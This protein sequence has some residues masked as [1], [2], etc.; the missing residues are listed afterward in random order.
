MERNKDAALV[1]YERWDTAPDSPEPPLWTAKW[2]EVPCNHVGLGMVRFDPTKSQC[3]GL[4]IAVMERITP[5][6]T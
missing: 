3:S 4:F 5:A 1:P 6:A 2:S